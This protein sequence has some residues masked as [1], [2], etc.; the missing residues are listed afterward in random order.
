MDKI[1]SIVYF[2]SFVLMF[3]RL[4]AEDTS[5]TDIVSFDVTIGGED[6]GT[7]DIGLFGDTVPLTVK[8]FVQLASG[9]EKYKY[10]GSPFHRVIDDFMIQ[11]GDVVY[12]NGSGETSI[13]GGRF[14]DENFLLQHYGAGWVSMANAGE[15]TNTCQ[16]FITAKNTY[17]LNDKHVVF[18]KVL[19]GM[20]VIRQILNTET[21]KETDTPLVPVLISKSRISKPDKTFTVAKVSADW[22]V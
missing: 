12:G 3:N 5:V 9:A 2:G 18:G 22:M 8:N 10:E 4:Y 6:V 16:F 20:R 14:E 11:G 21:N 19:R 7:I 17:W 13:Y 1:Y 15:N